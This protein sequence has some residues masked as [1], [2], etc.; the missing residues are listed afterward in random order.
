MK[1]LLSLIMCFVGFTAQASSC[2]YSD[3]TVEFVGS[4]WG[5]SPSNFYAKEGDRLCVK[6]SA[7]DG[8]KS[9]TISNT[10]IFLH[11]SPNQTSEQ[12]VVL[13]KTGELTVTCNGC[14]FKVN[15]AKIIVQSAREFDAYQKRNDRLNSLQNRNRFP[16]SG[17]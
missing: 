13:R 10:P 14:D 8:N 4:N 7:L 15:K 2:T 1:Y 9:L 12:M 16:T 17:H 5:F 11:A 6:F 3:A